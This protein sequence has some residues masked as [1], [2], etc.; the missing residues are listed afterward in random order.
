MPSQVYYSSTLN[1]FCAYYLYVCGHCRQ[2]TTCTLY[3]LTPPSILG[4]LVQE[5]A[6]ALLDVRPPEPMWLSF[7]VQHFADK[8]EPPPALVRN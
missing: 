7:V 8:A 6:S 1:L 3:L 4:A 5:V 2:L